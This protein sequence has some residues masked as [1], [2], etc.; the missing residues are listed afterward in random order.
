MSRLV[1][2]AEARFGAV[3]AALAVLAAVQGLALGFVIELQTSDS[4]GYTAAARAL[5]HGGYSTPLGNNVSPDLLLQGG[6]QPTPLA[7][8][9]ITGLR[10]PASVRNAHERQT[11]R[12][13][14][15]PALLAITGGGEERPARFFLYAVQAF[16]A[17]ASVVLLAFLARRLFGPRVALLAAGAYAVDPWTKRYVTLVMTETL[18]AFLVVATFYAFVRAWQGS[19]PRWWATAG[20]LAALLVLTRPAFALALPLLVLAPL[21]RRQFVGAAAT[22]ATAAALLVPWLAWTDAA[23]GRPV[24]SSFGEGWNLLL[25]AHG[26]GRGTSAGELAHD[27][28]Y[29]RDFESVHRFAPSAAELARDPNAHPH[30]LARADAE[31]RRIAVRLL[32]RRISAEPGEVAWETAFRGYVLWAVHTDWFQPANR[33]ALLVLRLADWITLLLALAGAAVGLARRGPARGLAIFLAAFTVL[34][35]VHHVEARYGIPL[36]GL[37]LMLSALGAV[38]LW[39]RATSRGTRR[40]TA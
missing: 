39:E 3:V 8:V 35:A 33:A 21:T 23:T 26:E 38:A 5:A 17:A 15:Y 28:A 1:A 36:R 6:A 34:N 22:A 20:G 37:V 12:T 7:D 30:Y 13:P 18:A 19:S 27:P 9:D 40:S 25:A 32:R 4:P 31:Q 24:L 10:L 11:M 2:A 29:L 14:A 16:L